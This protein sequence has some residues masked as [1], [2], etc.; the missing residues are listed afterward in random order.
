LTQTLPEHRRHG[1]QNALFAARIARARELGLT[2]LVTSTAERLAGRTNF[3]YRNIERAGFQ[4]VYVRPNWISPAQIG[5]HPH[6]D[7][8]IR[9]SDQEHLPRIELNS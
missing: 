1:V 3:S 8:G 2:T 9:R 5:P 6:T 4:L 7:V